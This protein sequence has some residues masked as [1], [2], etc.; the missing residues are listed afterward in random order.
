MTFH[1]VRNDEDQY[2]IW[3]DGRTLPDG[4]HRNGF[5][6]PREECLRRIE[7]EWTD[8]RPQSARRAGAQP[9]PTRWPYH[10]GMTIHDAVTRQARRRP[11]ALAIRQEGHAL[12]YEMLC[13]RSSAIAGALIRRGVQPGGIVAVDCP[14]SA[15]LV[16]V[17][18][19][20]LQAGAAYAAFDPAW[21][22][23]RKEQLVA[24]SAAAVWLSTSHSGDQ[25]AVGMMAFSALL[26]DASRS[27]DPLQDRQQV[28]LPTVSGAAPSSVFFTSGST[29][30]PKGIVSPHQATVR[31]VCE[32]DYA[33]LG[34]DAVFLQNAALPWDVLSLELWGALING[35]SVVLNPDRSLTTV[36]L[37]N[38]IS[39]RGVNTVWLTTSLLN[40]L[41]DEDVQS[42]G[43]LRT[44]VT[45][46]E[47]ASVHHLRLLLQVHSG[48]NLVNAY[49]PAESFITTT[50]CVTPT[51]VAPGRSEVPIGRPV[52]RTEVFLL[53]EQDQLIPPWAG[54]EEIG[55]I[56]I[57]GDGLGRYIG[58]DQ[59]GFT[60]IN[61]QGRQVA[62]YRTGDL[63]S[64]DADG[65]LYFRGRRDHQVKL[66]G[67]RI[68]LGEVEHAVRALPGVRWATAAIR[69]AAGSDVLVGWYL[70]DAGAPGD[71]Q[72]MRQ[73]L[74]ASLPAH[75][76]PSAL[77]WLPQLP[78]GP[79]GKLDARQLP[80]PK[81]SR[82]AG[83]RVHADPLSA[84]IAA[85]LGQLLLLDDIGGDEQIF[86][87]L[88]A[89]SL[90]ATR[91]AGMLSQ[92]WG[93]DLL[94]ND[95][96]SAPTTDALAA[97][98]HLR[99]VTDKRRA[100][101]APE[102]GPPALAVSSGQYR[103]W[104]AEQQYPGYAGNLVVEAFAVDGAVDPKRVSEA[105]TIV[106]RRHRQLRLRFTFA[107]G[108][109]H[110]AELTP[111][112]VADLG[113]DLTSDGVSGSP[114]AAA[115]RLAQAA[116]EDGIDLASG[117]PLRVLVASGLDRSVI[118]FAI[119]HIVI[120][121][122]SLQKFLADFA[123]A[124][125]G[126][127][128]VFPHPPPRDFFEHAA[129]EERYLASSRAEADN[130]WWRGRT[131]PSQPIRW[132]STGAPETQRLSVST[133]AVDPESLVS[134]ARQFGVPVLAAY[135]HA[136]GEAV[137]AVTGEPP[138]YVG[139]VLEGRLSPLDDEVIGYFSQ[140]IPVEHHNTL[141][142]SGT[143]LLTA[144]AHSR[145][146]FQRI[147]T[148]VSPQ[149]H[150]RHPLFQV[151]VIMQGEQ[152]GGLH[153]GELKA[154][155]VPVPPVPVPFDALLE[156]A[157]HGA[158]TTAVLQTSALLDPRLH[159]ALAQEL[160]AALSRTGG[161]R[162][163]SRTEE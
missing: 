55:E 63:G 110:I 150:E 54:E 62:V 92:Q 6:G 17:L 97:L 29:G 35:G 133:F 87:A 33:Q 127:G 108:D 72:V 39:Q 70:S 27:A 57:A 113:L 38:F 8:Q 15:D 123:A 147:I 47:R 5:A 138:P 160:Q 154:T 4:W 149:R 163:S 10:L 100:A 48:L 144:M 75:L 84:S 140:T 81:T 155:R 159:T 143:A 77:V 51:D 68:E 56:V 118:V 98:L 60:E 142:A 45:G 78:I 52:A 1:V 26:A 58:P 121:G 49:G 31:A 119:H 141:A 120:D 66:R 109:L 80:A 104:L 23:A 19:G 117:P 16:C 107:D 101:L 151:A 28:A 130:A 103:F 2:S 73:T 131:R 90:Q 74:A 9:R 126:G 65:V 91:L 21:P 40:T 132:P 61:L 111:E 136:M 88:G 162:G 18:L 94:V 44:I 89:S 11:D 76:V 125:R 86:A 105:L 145:L 34:P 32:P 161:N 124:Y 42:L 129:A 115:S 157:S 50:H 59:G 13:A 67:F 106:A 153:L 36:A 3:P 12:T 24:S 41:I 25:Q 37:R 137:E 158:V 114:E 152:P 14:R 85:V 71:E 96:Y 102:T 7:Q 116:I 99:G 93:T 112:Q 146:P 128:D 69:P 46:G 64:Y 95:V 134:S 139:T 148:A 156:I 30:R 43:G 135:L 83:P 20:I 22:T 122:W 82:E 53:S 79:T